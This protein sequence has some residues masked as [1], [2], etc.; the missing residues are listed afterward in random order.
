VVQASKDS[1]ED[2][3]SSFALIAAV[4]HADLELSKD[5]WLLSLVCIDVGIENVNG[6]D[7]SLDRCLLI[8]HTPY[9]FVAT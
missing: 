9:T 1:L 8:G 7:G 6:R 3:P 4:I 2:S 5:K